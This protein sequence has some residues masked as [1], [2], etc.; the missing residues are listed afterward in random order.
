MCYEEG[1][2]HSVAEKREGWGGRGGSRETGN[3]LGKVARKSLRS[4]KCPAEFDF[5][6]RGDVGPMGAFFFSWEE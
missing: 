5:S 2:T 3:G 1:V 6:S 4:L